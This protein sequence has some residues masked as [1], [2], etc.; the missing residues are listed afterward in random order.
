MDEQQEEEDNYIDDENLT[1]RI[2]NSDFDEA[3]DVGDERISQISE[4]YNDPI[5]LD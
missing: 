2:E 4:I 3:D 1:I 5:I